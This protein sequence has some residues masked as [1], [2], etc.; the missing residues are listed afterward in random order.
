MVLREGEGVYSIQSLVWQLAEGDAIAVPSRV[1]GKLRATSPSGLV[2]CYFRF[3]PEQLNSLLSLSECRLLEITSGRLGAIRFFPA[4]S[5][6]ARSYS[7]VVNN[8]SNSETLT[9]RCK[10]VEVIAAFLANEIPLIPS[11]PIPLVQGNGHSNGNGQNDDLLGKITAEEILSLSVGELA[12]K[13]GYSRR[14]LNRL[15]QERFGRSILG[16]K[17]ELRMDRAGH[18]LRN[19]NEK[20]INIAL[21]CGF[22]HFGLFR[23]KFRKRFGTIPSIWRQEQLNIEGKGP[24]Q[25]D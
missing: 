16:V 13:C 17:M 10:L 9:S 20:I 3:L 18:L 12:R 23:A 6:L 8:D 21:E 2:A 11:K 22:S 25:P 5:S 24:I 7:L 19:S 1:G 14:H 15:F 4:S